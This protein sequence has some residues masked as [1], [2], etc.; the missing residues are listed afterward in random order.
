MLASISV[1]GCER[2]F[3]ISLMCFPDLQDVCASGLQNELALQPQSSMVPCKPQ[4]CGVHSTNLDISRVGVQPASLQE[5]CRCDE[6]MNVA[7]RSEMEISL[8]KPFYI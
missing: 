1:L 7:C 4:P 8:N 5:P 2:V 6:V 3:C